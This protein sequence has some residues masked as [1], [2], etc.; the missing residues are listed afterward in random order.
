MACSVTEH[1]AC[2]ARLALPSKIWQSGKMAGFSLNPDSG[3]IVQVTT[4]HDEWL[5][6]RANAESLGLP[7]AAWREIVGL[8]AHRR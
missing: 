3:L 5:R 8:P 1:T 6:D 2:R 7:E 4:T